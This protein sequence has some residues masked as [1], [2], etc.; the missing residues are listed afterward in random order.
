MISTDINRL[1]RFTAM[2]GIDSEVVKFK[3][4]SDD[5]TKIVMAELSKIQKHNTIQMFYCCKT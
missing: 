2:R 3:I 4:F 5:Y 1:S